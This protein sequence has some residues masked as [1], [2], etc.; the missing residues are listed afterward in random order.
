MNNINDAPDAPCGRDANTLNNAEAW[1]DITL[2]QYTLS[3]P[4]SSS[5]PAPNYIS[6]SG[7]SPPASS[8]V[9]PIPPSGTSLSNPTASSATSSI[10]LTR[11][12]QL[13]GVRPSSS[14]STLTSI[15]VS[16]LPAFTPLSNKTVIL[17][18]PAA[19]LAPDNPIPLP[20][21]PPSA[22]AA[23]AAA[24]VALQQTQHS[25][26]M[27]PPTASLFRSFT[28]ETIRAFTIFLCRIIVVL[29]LPSSYFHRA[30]NRAIV[31]RPFIYALAVISGFFLVN[32]FRESL[33]SP[34][35]LFRQL[36]MMPTR[37]ALALWIVICIITIVLTGVCW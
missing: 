23:A 16:N 15:P 29:C 19:T 6:S 32:S 36:F 30:S 31:V 3:P 13:S 10:R 33:G 28:A 7:F 5:A 1:N 27:P 8:S 34:E 26:A 20:T 14:G 24:T 2:P 35:S 11:P 17:V 37:R 12:S 21:Y 4:S 18:P 9:S 22:T 25:A